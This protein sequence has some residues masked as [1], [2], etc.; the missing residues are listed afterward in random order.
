[1]LHTRLA[2]IA[3]L[4]LL[5]C[6]LFPQFSSAQDENAAASQPVPVSQLFS[7]PRHLVRNLAQRGISFQG[8]FVQDW[9]REWNDS[10][11]PASG[12]G[13]YSLDLTLAIDGEKILG[14]K[15]S[16]GSVRLK[17][18]INE[19]GDGDVVAAQL[20]SNIDACSKTMLYELWLEQRLFG[21]KL[22]LK[23]GKIDANTEFAVV[24]GAGDFLNSSMGYSPTIVAFST[25]PE[26]K[27]GLGVFVHP[28]KDY[29]F[30][31]GVFQTA[32]WGTLSVV[33]P[34]RRWSTRGDLS[35]RV[36]VG[37]WRLD[38]AMSR[39]D[40]NATSSTQGVYSV[41]EQSLWHR[42]LAGKDGERTFSTFLQFG[43]SNRA[44]S[45]FAS[46]VGGGVVLQAPAA[47]R[48][49]DSMGFA[50]TWVSLSPCPGESAN[51]TAELIL[52]S[53]YKVAVSKHFAFVQDLQYLH[54][55]GAFS[56]S[57]DGPVVSS[58]LAVSF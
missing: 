48:P 17:Q 1:V 49:R 39:M 11:A 43:R 25:Y 51:P 42:P 10:D 23:G 18:H 6:A 44:V 29:A 53:Y 2:R 47:R 27:L 8:M 34:G 16:T 58:R 52:E 50:A 12:F 38:G 3:I 30:G 55:P 9:S 20:Y 13:R 7:E 40:G 41:V 19:F 22:R 35:G 4:S 54:Q 31:L 21:E 24:E 26:P 37:Y 28:A 46:H 45:A 15:G 36:S 14:W 32:G 5:S 57:P 33:E 56:T